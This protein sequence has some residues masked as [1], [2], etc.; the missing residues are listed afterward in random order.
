VKIGNLS[1]KNNMFMAPMSGITNL[2]FRSVVRKFGCALAFTEM[3]SSSGLVRETEKSYRYLDSAPGDKPLGIQIFGSDPAILAGAVQIAMERGADL[4]DINMGCPVKKVVKAGAGAALMKDPAKVK[5]ILQNI[6]KATPLPMTIKIRS[7]W[8]RREINA[9]EIACIAEDCGVDAVIIHPRTVDQGFSGSADW[10]I[11]GLVKK[12]LLIPVIGSG[13]IMKPED[14]FRMIAMTGCDGVM[15]GR[16]TLGNP[17][18]F[19]SII[20]CMNHEEM[21]PTLLLSERKKVV[22]EHMNMEIL[23]MGEYLG[24]RHFRKHLFWY[25]KGLKGNSQFKQKVG[26]IDV[27]DLIIKEI[28]DFFHNSREVHTIS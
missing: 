16:A 23:Y 20:S 25:A 27:K 12:R 3:I 9:V 17:W 7:G 22:M 21:I 26:Q 8:N 1:L 6:R 13:D 2:P 5:L 28:C 14:A 18:I 24:I 4:L 19:K 11:I 15:V 10:N